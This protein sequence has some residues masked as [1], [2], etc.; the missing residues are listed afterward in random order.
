MPKESVFLSAE[1]RMDS[2]VDWPEMFRRKTKN[3]L[4]KS[5]VH[6]ESKLYQPKEKNTE[7]PEEVVFR[8]EQKEFKI[9]TMKRPIVFAKPLPIIPTNNSLDIL[10][11]IKDIVSQDYDIR[12]IA[13]ALETARDYIKSMILHSN[14]LWDMS[15]YVNIYKKAKPNVG[16]S[17]K[18]KTELAEQIERWINLIS[19]IQSNENGV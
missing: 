6:V 8:G 1:A 16:L 17:L 13:R 15:R 11:V 14:I 19:K 12:S 5:V 10:L 2:F 7:T 18:E 9:R 3:E 4:E